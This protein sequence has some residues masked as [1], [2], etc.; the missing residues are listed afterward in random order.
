MVKHLGKRFAT[1]LAQGEPFVSKIEKR[2]GKQ[3]RIGY[4]N[5]SFRGLRR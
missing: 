5:P 4:P 1:R 2:R 3:P